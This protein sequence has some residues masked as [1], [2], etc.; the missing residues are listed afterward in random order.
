MTMWNPDPVAGGLLAPENDNRSGVAKIV[1]PGALITSAPNAPMQQYGG[2]PEMAAAARGSLMGLASSGN[3]INGMGGGQL[4]SAADAANLAA[5]NAGNA[6]AIG[7]GIGLSGLSGMGRAADAYGNFSPDR[8]AGLNVA[9]QGLA[10]AQ[11]NTLAAA[12][13]VR[14]GNALTALRNAN[15]ANAQLGQDANAQMQLGGLQAYAAGDQARLRADAS[16]AGMLSNVGQG[17][18][19]LYGTGAGAQTSAYGAASQ[20][21]QGLQG[22][23]SDVWAAGQGGALKQD[24]AQYDAD[25]AVRAANKATQDANRG[26]V[27]GALGTIGGGLI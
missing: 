23:G 11:N 3:Y 9:R 2:S 8:M 15:I 22:I 18:G 26:G 21:A 1:D 27:L 25:S 4:L 5:N 20:R 13:T 16:R 12:G 14:G 19:S 24:I 17:Y 10:D 6:A 7:R